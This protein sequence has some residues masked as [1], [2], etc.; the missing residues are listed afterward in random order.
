MDR[1]AETDPRAARRADPLEVALREVDAAIELV[2]LGRRVA[3]SQLV[4]LEAAEQAAAPGLARRRRRASVLELRRPSRRAPAT[5]SACASV[6]R[7]VTEASSPEPNGGPADDRR[8]PAA[9]GAQARRP[10]RS[11]RPPACRLLP[12]HGPGPARRA[13]GRLA[14]A[15]ARRP[16]PRPRP[17]RPLRPPARVRGGD[18]GAAVQEEGARDLQLGRDLLV[19]LRDR[20]DP[21]RPDRRRGRR[22][23]ASRCRSRSRSRSCWPSSPIS[24]RQVC[25]AY[26][27]GGGA[28]AVSKANL[29][30]ARRARRRR[31]AAHRL[32]HDGRGLDG[33]GDRPDPI[34]SCPRPTTSGSRSRSS[35]ITLITI[36]NLRGLR[37]SGNIFAVP[38][39][40]FV[41]LALAM[42]GIGV[43]RIVDRAS[44]RRSPPARRDAARDRGRSAFSCC[45]RRSPRARSR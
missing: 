36:A 15:H 8:A 27:S 31:R 22:R 3:S 28:Y 11:R 34:R 33:I 20:G 41:G 2:A 1:A 25:L 44:G 35:P 7:L 5:A 21:A 16:V 42:V 39:Y 24:Y 37:E 6:P 9:Q 38:T 26:P 17:P 23:A 45:S 43:A 12:L 14:A 32:R 10:A 29:G 4:S 18:R 13:R 30:A 40:L 19:R